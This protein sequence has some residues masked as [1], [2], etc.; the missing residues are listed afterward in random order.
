MPLDTF[1]DSL[2]R[3]V[4]L[5]PFRRERTLWDPDLVDDTFWDVT[6][7]IAHEG[8]GRGY[9]IAIT[10]SGLFTGPD[11]PSSN[12]GYECTIT[13]TIERWEG[14]GEV[15]IVEPGE[16]RPPDWHPLPDARGLDAMRAHR[17]WVEGLSRGI[18]GRALPR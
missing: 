18:G 11:H 4:D 6:Q 8:P 10:Y 16:P 15:P 17:S 13:T 2:K 7:E 5:S 12:G 1:N 3:A 14:E 9:I